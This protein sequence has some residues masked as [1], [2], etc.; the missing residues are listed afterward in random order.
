[1]L[2]KAD[3][4]NIERLVGKDDFLEFEVTEHKMFVGL[5]KSL[6]RNEAYEKLERSVSSLQ[7][8]EEMA[9]L[10]SQGRFDG[11]ESWVSV[12]RIYRRSTIL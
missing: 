8:D 7:D 10:L 9:Y 5:D 6:R 11:E 12:K 1:M 3:V 4:R 2:R